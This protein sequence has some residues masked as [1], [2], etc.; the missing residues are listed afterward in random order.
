MVLLLVL[1]V[2][3]YA[4]SIHKNSERKIESINIEF[5]DNSKPFL[6]EETVSK[7]LIQNEQKV[8]S[9][10]KEILD[11]NELESALN[12]NKIIKKAEVYMS[13]NGQLTAKIEQKTPIARVNTN[14]SYYIDDEGNFMP[15]STNYT[16]RVPLVTGHVEKNNLG[17]IFKVAKKIFDDELLR[18]FVVRIHQNQNSSIYLKLR[19]SDFVVNIGKVK[20]LDRKFDN[21]KAFYQKAQKDKTLNQYSKVN[22]QFHN[23]VVCTKN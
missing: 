17:N 16:A 4:F 3:L 19:K 5:K 18:K 21:L 12:A 9:M 20:H 1:V 15:L 23:Q 14:A 2:F 13:V 7:L 8:T 11:L 6:T 10:P 22:L